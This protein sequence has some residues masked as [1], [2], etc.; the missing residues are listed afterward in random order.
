MVPVILLLIKEI[1]IYV[2][3]RQKSTFFSIIFLNVDSS[4]NI[5]DRQLNFSVVIIDM[6]MEGTVSQ[7]SYLG[8]SLCFMRLQK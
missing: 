5:Y 8:P 3:K 4:L 7:I 6:M 1:K 2:L